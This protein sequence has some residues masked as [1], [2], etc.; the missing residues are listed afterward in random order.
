MQIRRLIAPAL[1]LVAVALIAL[2]AGYF[3]ESGSP[4]TGGS[5]SA[6][7]DASAVRGVVQEAGG[8]SLTLTTSDGA[9]KLQLGPDTSIEALQRPASF[10]AL[11]PGDWLNVG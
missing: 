4:S 6:A 5:S 1:G 8:D 11:Q 10:A 7:A 2:V 9:V 3:S